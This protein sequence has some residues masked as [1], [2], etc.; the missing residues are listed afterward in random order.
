MVSCLA[1]RTGAPKDAW[2]IAHQ[3]HVHALAAAQRARNGLLAV[4][5]LLL[6]AVTG[7]LLWQK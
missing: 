2:A 1:S 7:L 6:P 3:A 4:V 5:A